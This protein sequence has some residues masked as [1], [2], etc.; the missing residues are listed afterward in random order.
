MR[1]PARLQSCGSDDQL[2]EGEDGW[3]ESAKGHGLVWDQRDHE[4]FLN[5][6]QELFRSR[7]WGTRP[8]LILCES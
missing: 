3:Q 7:R 2:Q 5:D 4:A 8:L 1:W 6:I